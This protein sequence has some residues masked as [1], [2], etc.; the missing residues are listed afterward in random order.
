MSLQLLPL[1]EK[2]SC[3]RGRRLRSNGAAAAPFA[4]V[5]GLSGANVLVHQMIVEFF[6]RAERSRAGPPAAVMFPISLAFLRPVQVCVDSSFSMSR[7]R[8]RS[9]E[10]L[11]DQCSARIRLLTPLAAG[12]TTRL[13]RIRRMICVR[14]VRMLIVFVVIVVVVAVATATAA[15][16]VAA[17]VILVV[18][19]PCFFSHPAAPI[20]C[21][22]RGLE[23][24]RTALGSLHRSGA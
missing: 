23:S 18:I 4:R 14:T 24:V 5:L 15:T 21:G 16:A 8:M 9:G 13:G 11:S 20:L 2:P 19:A 22:R 12:Q 1:L 17:G 6:D 3:G 7:C 10:F